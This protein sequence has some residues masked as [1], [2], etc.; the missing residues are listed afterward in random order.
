MVVDEGQP[1]SKKARTGAVAPHDL[2]QTPPNQTRLVGGL[3]QR[4]EQG[5]NPPLF[6]AFVIGKDLILLI[7][8]SCVSSAG[9]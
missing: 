1:V 6:C 8:I 7:C 3:G 9:K 2:P 5:P 4:E